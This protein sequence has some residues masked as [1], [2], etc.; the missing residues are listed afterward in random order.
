MQNLSREDLNTVQ[1]ILE[2]IFDGSVGWTFHKDENTLIFDGNDLIVFNRGY[3][4][5]NFE[6]FVFQSTV[7]NKFVDYRCMFAKEVNFE[8]NLYQ[9]RAGKW[10]LITSPWNDRR[11]AS[12][13]RYLDNPE[14]IVVYEPGG[15]NLIPEGEV[16]YRKDAINKKIED[17]NGLYPLQH[18]ILVET[19]TGYRTC[20]MKGKVAKIGIDL[21]CRIS[22][23]QSKTICEN[24]EIYWV[25]DS[26]RD[27]NVKDRIKFGCGRETCLNPDHTTWIPEKEAIAMIIRTKMVYNP[28]FPIEPQVTLGQYCS[29]KWASRDAQ[30]GIEALKWRGWPDQKIWEVIEHYRPQCEQQYWDQFVIKKLQDLVGI[31]NERDVPFRTLRSFNHD[32]KEI[33]ETAEAFNKKNP[34]Q[35]QITNEL[36]SA[37]QQAHLMGQEIKQERE[38]GIY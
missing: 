24:S 4:D 33:T 17:T 7:Q 36:L 30:I 25:S 14:H 37:L 34:Q 31:A 3:L 22:I 28:L 9:N 15:I 6:N 5:P 8:N 23:A 21:E 27:Y 19:E 13:M 38:Y 10:L 1:N 26:L 20:G 16:R 11:F 18:K 35:F 12:A 32:L 2:G 29:G